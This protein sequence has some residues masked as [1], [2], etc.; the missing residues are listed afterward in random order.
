VPGYA[1]KI[2]DETGRELNPP[3]EGQLLIKGQSTCAYYWNKWDKT[4]ETILG[5]WI[6]TGDKYHQDEDGYYWYH[7]R[8]D[9]M[10]KAGGIW[11]SP[12]E[13][14]NA[15]VEHPAVQETGV[16]G[17]MDADELVKPCAF[18][19]VKAGFTADTALE[20]ELKQFVKDRIAVYKYPRWIV[21]VDSLPRTATGKLQRFKLREL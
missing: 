12:V 4:R 7:G 13:V 5:E 19:V 6:R 3:E 17:R 15:L 18:I 8:S 9:D 14:E 16:I 1:A 20:Q 11:V 2:V 21:F 10:I